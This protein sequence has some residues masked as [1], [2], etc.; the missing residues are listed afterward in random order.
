[1]SPLTRTFATAALLLA[2]L[3]PT[4]PAFAQPERPRVRP[5]G[6]TEREYQNAKKALRDEIDRYLAEYSR[7]S[8]GAT[9]FEGNWTVRGTRTYVRRSG[10]E[11]QVGQ[12]EGQVLITRQGERFTIAGKVAMIGSRGNRWEAEGAVESGGW[13]LAA[14]YDATIAGTGE[15]THELAADG[16]SFTLR[17]TS[18]Q[19]VDG[20]P[21]A[22]GEGRGER[23]FG[24]LSK[25]DV[26]RKLFELNRELQF[27]RYPRPEPTRYDARSGDLSIRFTPT[28]EFDPDG[29]EQQ[30]IDMIGQ[31]ERS[32]DLCLFEF[33][34][35][36]V[37]EALVAAHQRG[38]RVR[39]VYDDREEEQPA[40]HIVRSAGIEAHSD[41]R[42]AY[43]HNKFILVDEETV[44]TGS[45]NVAP[46]GVYVGD[47][48]ALT[49]QS[50]RLAATYKTEFEEMFVD[51]SFGTTSPQ[52]T[53]HTP[54][55]I[56][57]YTKVETWFAP[58]D[59]AMDR[60]IEV[61]RTARTSIKFMVFAFTSEALFQAILER[62]QAGVEVT[63][64]FESRHAGW[65]DI[66]IGPLHQ[67]GAT[68]RFDTNPDTLHHKVIIVD[69]KVVVTGSFN[70][71]D[72]TDRSNDENM[73]VIDG[74]SVARAFSRE[75][76]RLLSVTD[77]NDPRIATA[78][79]DGRDSGDSD[80][81]R[82]EEED[83]L[84]DALNGAAA[85]GAEE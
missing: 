24:A 30:I 17:F 81:R 70:F 58:E 5:N 28:V 12:F 26:E 79:M 62:M 21:K 7:W 84:I 66:K 37:A 38:V 55:E 22:R 68:V 31:A 13:M 35:P 25:Q 3:L 73:L 54:V 41:G 45:T 42:S 23:T 40:L 56:D 1:M 77:P 15:A 65:K 6:M 9:G 20:R 51:G 64:I 74:R 29:V 34:L 2:A 63:G 19:Q 44:W 85:A 82:D 50:E 18:E 69:E 72:S 75:L 33:S 43:M 80:E 67:A 57:R 60:M 71:S 10:D 32:I 11:P 36:R 16:Q 53:D 61:V 52:N 46:G 27:L 59:G 47:N 4:P 14:A 48:H 39:M 76:D 83:G 49:I 78:G 8:E